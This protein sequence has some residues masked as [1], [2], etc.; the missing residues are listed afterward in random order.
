[1]FARLNRG[2]K[3]ETMFV[4]K[5][6]GKLLLSCLALTSLLVLSGCNINFNYVDGFSFD[7]TGE[8]AEKNENDSIAAEVKT[9]EIE[10]RFGDV[11]IEATD[12]EF[13][14]NW[15]LKVWADSSDDANAYL[16]LIEMQVS[17]DDGKQTWR[18]IL[19]EENKNLLKGV[20][21][22]LTL[23]VPKGVKTEMVNR[24]GD[25]DVR[26]V[27]GSLDLENAH[28]N[29]HVEDLSGDAKVKVSHGNLT[30]EGM[31]FLNAE[32]RHGK[33]DVSGIASD[34][35]IGSQHG[36]VTLG[37]VDGELN[38]EVSHGSITANNVGGTVN[39][40]ASHSNVK[41]NELTQNAEI[42]ASH[43]S[44]KLT[45]P[46]DASPKLDADVSHGNMSS[47]FENDDSGTQVLKL[48][49]KHGNISVKKS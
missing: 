18:L 30:G 21:S 7:Y 22:N 9:I 24:H 25:S 2:I 48:K 42:S 29:L 15:D 41:I 16:E 44:I 31:S 10:N 26:G 49:A 38:V 5:I 3:E 34:C 6:T 19:P 33:I 39:I 35:K 23:L 4:S 12:G 8:T 13:G 1:M 43:G 47:D 17:E 20:K 36:N 40:D 11:K 37:S 46:A 32:V 45:L 27:G 28:G 14:W